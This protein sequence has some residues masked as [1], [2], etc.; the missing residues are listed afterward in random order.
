TSLVFLHGFCNTADAYRDSPAFTLFRCQGLRVVLPT[1]P[2]L[3]IVAHQ[4]VRRNAWYNYLTDHDG[5]QEDDIDEAS[6]ATTRAMVTAIVDAEARELGSHGRVLLGGASQG[7]CAA[8][9]AFARHPARLGGFVGF[10]GHP[11]RATPVSESR[12][13]DVPCAFYSGAADQ[14]MRLSWV[15]PAIQQLELAG[16]SKV[17]S[18]IAPGVDHG[19]SEELES[20]LVLLKVICYVTVDCCILICSC[21]FIF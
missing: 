21:L 13:R 1:A 2:V 5:Q 12:Q 19:T 18:E 9:D 3:R 20:Q 11:L 14:T 4:G 6:L 10:V 16:W 7:C 8:F 15:R 17:R